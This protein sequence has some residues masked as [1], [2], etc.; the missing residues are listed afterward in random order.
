MRAVRPVEFAHHRLDPALRLLQREA[1]ARVVHRGDAT[2][3]D[4]LLTGDEDMAH[5]PVVYADGPRDM[6][7]LMADPH[8]P[9]FENTTVALDELQVGDFTVFW[10]NR[11]YD[12]ISG[13]A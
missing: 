9:Y 5:G 1:R 7:S 11:V 3:A 12:A 2:V 6:G 10:N 4:H 8:D 13:G